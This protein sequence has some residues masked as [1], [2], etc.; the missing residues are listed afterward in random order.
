M[1]GDRASRRL[2]RWRNNPLRRHDDLV[3]AW[4]VLAVYAGVAVGGTVAGAVTAQAADQ[5][6]AQQRAERRAVR[7]VLVTDAPKGTAPD[8]MGSVRWTAPDGSARTGPTLVEAGLP[9]GSQVVVWQDGRGRLVAEPPDA[10]EAGLEAAVLGA[11]AA[12]ATAGVVLGAGAVARWR[13][14]R[15]RIA[16][17]GRE[18]DLVEPKWGHRTG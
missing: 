18:W 2:W 4:I 12:G 16:R 15:R 13:L 11:G 10:A 1:Q 14:D 7:A 9:A 5:V 3:E 8:V 6:F 17:W